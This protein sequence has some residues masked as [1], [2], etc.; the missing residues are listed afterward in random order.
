MKIT[1]FHTQLVTLPADEPLA[2]GPTVAGAGRSFVTLRLRT[3][4][5]IEGIGI[6]YFGAALVA[7]LRSGLEQLAALAVGQDPMRPEAVLDLLRQRARPSGPAG[8]FTLAVA[9]LDLAM[10]DI[11]G[12]ALGASVSRLLGGFRTEVPAYASGAMMREFPLE[13]VVQAGPRLLEKGFT[14][15]KMQL[16]LHGPASNARELERIR[17][18]REAIGPDVD[19]M[20]DINQRWNVRQAISLGRRLEEF[21]LYW[22]EDIVAHDDP[23]GMAR[24]A[25]ALDT[26]LAAGEYL[27]GIAPMRH[28]MQANAVDIVMIDLMRAGGITGWMKIAGMA[29]AFNLPVVSHLIP[30]VHAHLVAAIPNGLTVEYMPWASPLFNEKLEMKNG[31]LQVPDRPGLGLTFD[32]GVLARYAAA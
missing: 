32:E 11:K 23:P 4:E 29:E 9:A 2:D 10:W 17:L 1:G 13:Q 12:K 15:M 27:Y 25:E 30:E 28:L 8:I 6:T 31:L 19:L 26:P 24:V 22:L 5:G 16:A 7:T 18:V 3:D 21:H 14:Q 20:C